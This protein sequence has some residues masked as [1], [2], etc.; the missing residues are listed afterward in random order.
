MLSTA[1]YVICIPS[2]FAAHNLTHAVTIQYELQD[3]NPVQ[4]SADDNGSGASSVVPGSKPSKSQQD[5]LRKLRRKARVVVDHVDII[6]DEFWDRRPWI[7][8]NT[9]GKLPVGQ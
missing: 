7:L 2:I 5:K 8:S 3:P 9:P 1:R 6:K 4:T